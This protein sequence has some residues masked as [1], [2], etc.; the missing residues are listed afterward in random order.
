M[1]IFILVKVMHF[2]NSRTFNKAIKA[3]LLSQDDF[4]SSGT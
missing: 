2:I 4:F 3:S 1:S